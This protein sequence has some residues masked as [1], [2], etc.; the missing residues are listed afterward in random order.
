MIRTLLAGGLAALAL[1][2]GLATSSAAATNTAAAET[3]ATSSPPPGS[4]PFGRIECL[5]GHLCAFHLDSAHTGYY[6]SYY[7][8]QRIYLSDWVGSGEIMNN[9]STGTVTTFYGQSGNVISTSKA[10]QEV[11]IDWD[12]VWSFQVC[13]S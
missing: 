7:Y 2:G 5:A 4:R 10:F 3:P 12:P 11:G 1:A 9:Q 6:T 13:P 8:C